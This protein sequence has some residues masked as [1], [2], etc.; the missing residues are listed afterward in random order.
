MET[1]DVCRYTAAIDAIC[2]LK[3]ETLDRNDLL[4]VAHV[5]HVFSVQFRENLEITLSLFP[6]DP[7]LRKL[8][9]EECATDNLSPWP[10]VAAAGEPMNHD[11]FM[12]RT[13]ELEPIG[14]EAR[15]R[16]NALGAR[17]LAD[18]RSMDDISRALTIASYEDGGLERVFNAFLMAPVWTGPALQAFRHFLVEHIRFDSDPDEGH[19][20][21]SRHLVP[22]DRV[23][24]A[25]DGFHEF[26]VSAVPALV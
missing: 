1:M 5:Y 10:G 18:M 21:L 23:A 20:A 15:Q 24:P 3:W 14:E 8:H 16:I 17:Y 11:E 6:H 26:L 19:G 12:R 7:K 13:L 25:W 4:R 22:D 2:E 9:A